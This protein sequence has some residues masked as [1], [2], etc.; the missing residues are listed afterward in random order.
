M[1]IVK[2]LHNLLRWGVLIFGLWTLLNAITGVIGKRKY[3]ASDNRSNLF[4]MIFCDIQLLL[5]LILYFGNSWFDR[6]KDLGNNMKDPYNRFFTME[7]MS[8]MIVAWILVHVGRASVKRANTDAAK[9][10]RMLLFFGLAIILI[11]V[12]IPWPFRQN[13]G[14]PYFRWFN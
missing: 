12:S 3:A 13:I 9:H 10:K 14:Q 5:G 1:E 8:M 2:V 4:F 6:L 11:L 7:H